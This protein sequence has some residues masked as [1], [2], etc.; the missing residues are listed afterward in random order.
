MCTCR[1]RFE[2]KTRDFHLQEEKAL[3]HWLLHTEGTQSFFVITSAALLITFICW[4]NCFWMVPFAG[5][6]HCVCMPAIQHFRNQAFTLSFVPSLQLPSYQASY[7]WHPYLNTHKKLQEIGKS[8][9]TQCYFYR[10]CLHHITFQSPKS[11]LQNPAR[12]LDCKV[13]GLFTHKEGTVSSYEH[14]AYRIMCEL[15]VDVR[16][17]LADV[18]VL[19]GTFSSADIWV[20]SLRLLIMIDGEGHFKKMFSKE[21]E[22][23]KQTDL[24]FNCEAFR[25]KYCVLRL[26]YEDVCAFGRLIQ[27]SLILAY[28]ASW[29]FFFASSR[30][31]SRSQNTVMMWHIG[32]WEDWCQLHEEVSALQAM[33][34]SSGL[35]RKRELTHHDF[36][37]DFLVNAY[38]SASQTN[39]SWSKQSVDSWIVVQAKLPFPFS[40]SCLIFTWLS[41]LM[42][43][44]LAILL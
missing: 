19:R 33:Q 41:W 26:H 43:G 16:D 6:P 36:A 20:R 9:E 3:G 8:E 11:V 42:L 10:I 18:R 31:P 37:E 4:M 44:D 28:Y 25:Q 32:V 40:W 14:L 7:Y 39:P 1:L 21:A 17:W 15:G 2:P 22:D 23:Q 38:G 5:S 34:A 30:H 29:P 13:C 12:C 24:D 27:D 35:G